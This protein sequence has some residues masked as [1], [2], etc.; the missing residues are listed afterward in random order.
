MLATSKLATINTEI[1]KSMGLLFFPCL[2]WFSPTNLPATCTDLSHKISQNR[3]CISGTRVAAA[4]HLPS[5]QEHCFITTTQFFS[6]SCGG[7]SLMEASLSTSPCGPSESPVL[8][9]IHHRWWNLI[10]QSKYLSFMKTVGHSS[11]CQRHLRNVN[12]TLMKTRFY[13]MIINGDYSKKKNCA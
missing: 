8:L 11:S 4:G 3:L 2:P 12:Q 7:S 5:L 10:K 9:Q 6:S 13:D 1:D